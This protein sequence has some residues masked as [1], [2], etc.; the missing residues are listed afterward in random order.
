MRST[1]TGFTT[2][3]SGLFASQRALDITGHNLAN[4]NTKGYS[5]Q[6]LEQVQST[7]LKLAGGQ[8][9]LGTGVDTTAIHQLRNE[10]LDYKYRD[11][12]TSLGYWSAKADGLAF[13]ESIMNEPSDTGISKVISQMFESFDELS[14]NADNI[15]T[16]A[17]VRQRATTFTNSVN[18]MYNQL[19]KMVV[20]YNFDVQ[21]MVSRINTYG[22]Q[23]ARLNDQILRF[24]V[25]GSN[26]NDLRDQRNVLIDELSEIVDVDVMEVTNPSTPGHKQMVIKVGGKPLVYHKDFTGLQ[27]KQELKQPFDGMTDKSIHIYDIEWNDGTPFYVSENIDKDVDKIGGELGAILTMRD[28]K[29]GKNKGIPHYIN[30][31]NKFVRVFA[32]EINKIH[33]DGYG[34]DGN[35]GRA[36]FTA[37]GVATPTGVTGA[38]IT[39]N[40]DGSISSVGGHSEFTNI[41]A[42]NIRIAF[43]IEDPNN[44][45]ASKEENLLPKDGSI[46]LDILNLRHKQGMFKEGKPEDFIKSLIGTLGVEAEEADNNALNQAVL[47]TEIDNKRMSISGVFQDEELANMVKFQH[48][49]NASARMMTTIDEMLD[50]LINKIG[51][52]GR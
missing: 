25:D 27:V 28:G 7:P 34:L 29:G 41:N 32:N 43:D 38:D 12:A 3:K 17:L 11:E 48:A 40:A 35:T 4:V 42:S 1:F 39:I 19:E 21:S 30:E 26:A 10:L 8:G 44:I 23:I 33:L 51:I 5:R 37:K 16:R 14:K 24:E 13:I 50:V 15:T 52:V 31:L 2:A 6:R 45:A 18:H 47:L 9:M 49:Y 46:M 36:F 20:D 22:E